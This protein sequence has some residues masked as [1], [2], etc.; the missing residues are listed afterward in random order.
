MKGGQAYSQEKL[1]EIMG[2]AFE[3]VEFREMKEC[4]ASE[5]LFGVPFLSASL[6]RKKG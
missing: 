3:L 4:D 2:E 5:G 1:L 6:W